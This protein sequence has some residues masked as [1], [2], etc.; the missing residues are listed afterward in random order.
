MGRTA[1]GL[2]GVYAAADTAAAAKRAVR[3]ALSAHL[4]AVEKPA[5]PSGSKPLVVVLRWD[6]AGLRY[7]GLGALLGRKASP[8]KAAAARR[9]GM[10][11]G[12]PRTRSR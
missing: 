12:R 1:P 8:A 3:G 11:G 6:A 4:E 2:P 5:R 7:V 10:K 9:N